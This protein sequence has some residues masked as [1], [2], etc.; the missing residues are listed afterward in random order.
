[1]HLPV[2]LSKNE[3]HTL[4]HN[5]EQSASQ[6]AEELLRK[7]LDNEIEVNRA[8]D[9]PQATTLSI[10]ENIALAATERAKKEKTTVSKILQQIIHDELRAGRLQRK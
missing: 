2:Y 9:K 10:D 3:I 6:A 4:R 7:W 1:M 5:P 8:L